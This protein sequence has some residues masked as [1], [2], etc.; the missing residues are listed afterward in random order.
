M[1]SIKTTRIADL[2]DPF[3]ANTF[4]PPSMRQDDMSS[5]NVHPN[6][7]GIPPQMNATMPMPVAQ[8]PSQNQSQPFPPPVSLGSSSQPPTLTPD[9][10]AMLQQMP[11][12]HLPSRDIPIDTTQYSQDMATKPNYIPQPRRTDDYIQEYERKTEK[13]MRQY[14]IEKEIDASNDHLFDRFQR[15]IMIALLFLIYSLPIV[16]TLVFKRLVFL[17]IFSEDGNMNIYGQILKS[18]FFGCTFW[19]FENGMRYLSEI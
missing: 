3:T 15:P 4:Q 14:E 7:Y 12:Q 19:S 6:P 9:Q 5:M 8:P 16:N 17:P 13:K 11:Q 10:L 1:D 2:P 18:I